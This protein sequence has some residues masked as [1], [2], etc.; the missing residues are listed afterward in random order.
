MV[1]YDK[2]KVSPRPW[3]AHGEYD[4]IDDYEYCCIYDSSG[5]RLYWDCNQELEDDNL[6]HLVHCVNLHDELVAWM[7][8]LLDCAVPG[9]ILDDECIESGNELIARAGGKSLEEPK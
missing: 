3:K 9:D 4:P 6:H 7:T 1:D 2:S 5:N 8:E